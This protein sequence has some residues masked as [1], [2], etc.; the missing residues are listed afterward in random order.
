MADETVEQSTTESPNPLE[1]YA[2]FEKHMNSGE[3]PEAVAAP[4]AAADPATDPPAKTPPPESD[5]ETKTQQPGIKGKGFQR[6]IDDLT[7]ENYELRA[8]LGTPAAAKTPGTVSPTPADPAAKTGEPVPTDFETYDEYVKALSKHAYREAQA[9][10]K[11]AAAKVQ[12]QD[13][14]QQV[15]STFKGRVEEFKSAHPDYEEI[16]TAADIPITPAFR[17]AILTSEDGPKLAYY[18]A[19]HQDECAAIAELDEIQ[20]V[21]A[22]GKLEAKLEA[23]QTPAPKVSKA[24]PPPQRVNAKTAA[25][26]TPSLYDEATQNDFAAWEKLRNAEL[27]AK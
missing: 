15:L 6:R 26:A 1:D 4:S 8:Q 18:L 11:Q 12:A 23:A 10:E 7:R 22:L 13:N 19:S 5:P 20:Q 17:T 9:E 27:A 2:A 16:V 21:R 24:P 14:E 25:V 3:Q